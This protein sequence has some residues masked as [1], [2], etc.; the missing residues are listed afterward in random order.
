MISFSE[1]SISYPD[2]LATLLIE[3]GCTFTYLNKTSVA[4]SAE[5]TLAEA[6]NSVFLRVTN[7]ALLTEMFLNH[8]DCVPNPDAE[9]NTP[10]VLS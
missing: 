3:L 4:S 10:F 5:S 8:W 1:P 6:S 2:N 7:T 9:Y